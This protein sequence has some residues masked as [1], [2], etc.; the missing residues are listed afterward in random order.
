MK[1]Y[2]KN[3]FLQII[4]CSE[5]ILNKIL[6]NIENY[7]YEFEELKYNEDKS[8]KIKKGVIQKRYYNPSCKELR[9]IQDKIQAKILSTIEL[10]PNILGGTKGNSNVKNAAIHKGKKYRFQ[11]DLTNFFP[12]VSPNMVFNALRRKGISKQVSNLI[13]KLT[14]FKTKDSWREKSLPQGPPTSPQLSN[15]VFESIDLKILNL[16]ENKNI[17]YTRWIDDLTF[18]SNEDFSNILNNIL[19]LI[20][21]NGLKVSRKK[22]TYR[23]NK[24]VITGVVAGMSSL[25]VTNKFR[26]K[27]NNLLNEYQTAGRKTYKNYVYKMDKSKK[28]E[29][30]IYRS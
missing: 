10:I 4:G 6:N 7:Y 5:D 22:T 2:T 12:S 8:I 16:I 21:R 9:E 29:T 23:K 30:K 1:L 14:T 27:E 13:T 20:G 26:S 28:L 25:K 17:Y 19:S 24:S 11:T 15:I 18:S 3:Q